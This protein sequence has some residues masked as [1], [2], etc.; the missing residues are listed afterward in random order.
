MAD[1]LA[2]VFVM[3]ST[4]E[5]FGIVFLEAMACGCPV[6][7]GNRDGSVDALAH[8]EL[9]RLVD[10]HSSEELLRALVDT[11][12]EPRRYDRPIPGLERFSIPCFRDRV[13]ALVAG[14]RP[15]RR[16]RKG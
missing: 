6:V 2:D 1:W 14:L 9:G 10:P 4:G 11:L 7:A 15:G 8:G 16:I 12:G 5:G 3:P 13:D